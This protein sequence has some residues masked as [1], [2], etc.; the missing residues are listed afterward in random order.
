MDINFLP[1]RIE[2]LK[3]QCDKTS[4]PKFLGFLTASE[5]AAALNCLKNSNSHAFFGGYEGAERTMLAFLPHWCKQPQYPITAFTFTY[6]ACDSLIHRDFLGALMALGI[7]RETVGDILVGRGEAVVFVSNDVAKFVSTQISKIGNVGVKITQGFS[8]PLPQNSKKQ[9]FVATV[10]STRLD[11]VVSALCGI[12]RKEAS[13]KI[14]DG[15]V[16]VNS[17]CISKPTANISADSKITVRQSG[18]FEIMSC[19]E[20]SKKGRII[21]KYNKYV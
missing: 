1:A 9:S 8:E 3:Q 21:L 19:D 17:V 15:F 5:L 10:A 4:S 16:A 7:A 6:R 14:S 20:Y 13:N 2:D 11:C 12:S 18:K